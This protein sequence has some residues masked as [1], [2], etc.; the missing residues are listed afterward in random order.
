MKTQELRE[1]SIEELSELIV[2]CKKELFEIRVG[3]KTED[4]SKISKARK[5]IARAKTIIN[6]K[7][8]NEVTTNA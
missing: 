5:T 7:K 2:N 1:K 6:E 8:I 4:T 3:N